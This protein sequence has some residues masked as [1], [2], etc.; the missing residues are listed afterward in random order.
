MRTVWLTVLSVFLGFSATVFGAD[1]QP[2]Q[3]PLKTRWAADVTAVKVHADYPRP[4][5]VRKEWLNLNGVWEFSE[6]DDAESPPFGKLLPEKIM[7]PFPVESALSGVMRNSERVWYRRTFEL[8]RRWADQQVWLHFG[9]VDW[10]ATVY[11]NGRKLGTHRGGYTPFSFDVTKE[12]RPAG[13][14]ELIVHVFDPADKGDQ[15]RGKQVLNPEGIWYT[16]STGIWQTVWLEPMPPVSI[17]NL[18]II[19]SPRRDGINLTVNTKGDA[20]E[21][22]VQATVTVGNRPISGARGKPGES[23]NIPVPNPRLWSPDDPYLYDLTVALVR[24]NRTVDRVESYFGIRTI[25]IMSDGSFPRLMLNGE[26]TFQNG[27]LDQGFWPDG[28][29]TAPNDAAIR[30]DLELIKRLGFNMVRKHVKIEPQR[31][32]YWCD[33]IGLLVWQDMPNGNNTTYEAKQQFEV[34]LRS[35]VHDLRNHPSVIVWI[36]FNEAWGQ[37]DTERL[38]ELVKSLD[39]HRLVTSASGWDDAGVGDIIDKH[40]Y[41]EPAAPEADGKR[42]MVQGEYG[43]L[44]LRVPGHM[45]STQAWGYKEAPERRQLLSSCIDLLNQAQS[46]RDKGLSAAVYT[47]LTDVETEANGLLTYDRAVLK[48]DV[49]AIAAALDGKSD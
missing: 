24:G 40:D 1:W 44:A 43:G 33:R 19:T 28:L 22:G 16:S 36:L 41:P 49:A 21:Y 4:Q 7:V 45:W 20:G 30:H 17:A 2:A 13:P 37:F 35:M 6:A 47:Q 11:F 25:E 23:I 3:G 8:P 26:F 31:W 18:D 29:Y 34:E 46:F 39:P 32:Y 9:A 38:T 27:I 15:P 5:M 14:Q 48:V 42:A 10:E 12:L